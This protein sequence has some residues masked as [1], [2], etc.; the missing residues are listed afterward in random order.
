[1]NP[2][3]ASV[4]REAGFSLVELMV[5]M[6]IGLIAIVVMFQVFSVTES[7]RRTTTGAGD[8]QQNGSTALF[9]MERDVRMAGYGFS[10]WP[11]LGC[12]GHGFYRKTGTAF[13]FTLAPVLVTDGGAKGSDTVTFM[14]GNPDSYALPAP[15]ATDTNQTPGYIKIQSPRFMFRPGDVILSSEMPAAGVMK[16]CWVT[17]V[18]DLPPEPFADRVVNQGGTYVDNGVTHTAE[19]TPPFVIPVTYLKWNPVKAQGGRLFNLGPQPVSMTYSIVNNQLVAT[20]AFDG[21]ATPIADNIVQFQV[22]VGYSSN[23]QV[24]GLASQC[25]I[26]SLAPMVSVVGG[27]VPTGQWGDKLPT[28][29]SSNDYRS[30]IAVRMAIVARSS[31]PEK[32]DTFGNCTAS[33]AQPIWSATGATLWVDANPEWRCYRYKVFELVMPLRNML[34]FADPEGSPVPPA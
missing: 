23:C 7:Q 3:N 24:L 31:T 1:V 9:I 6:V 11:L 30:V 29:P 13:D 28:N 25:S 14:Y 4:R 27:I 2:S 20:N 15:L 32:K 19:Y 18:T 26:N 5:G 10:Y 12:K 34:W 17:Q 8:A 22:Q 21:V 33:S 16:D